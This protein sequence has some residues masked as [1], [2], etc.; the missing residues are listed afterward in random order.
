MQL[1]VSGE[2]L[3]PGPQPQ[4]V[5]QTNNHQSGFKR[6]NTVD[7]ATIK[8]NSAR[9]NARPASAQ[10]KPTENSKWIMFFVLNFL[11]IYIRQK[12]LKLLKMLFS[13]F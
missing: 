10:P 13:H 5:Q 9:L 2:T 12:D 11:S 7:S 6:Q 4:A 8:E 1:F 3:R